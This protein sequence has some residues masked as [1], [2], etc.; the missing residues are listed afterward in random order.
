M[1]WHKKNIEGDKIQKNLRKQEFQ[2]QGAGKMVEALKMN[3]WKKTGW[4]NQ[5]GTEEAQAG[6]RNGEII[7]GNTAIG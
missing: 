7:S 5:I 3:W 2:R 6:P 1:R 4:I